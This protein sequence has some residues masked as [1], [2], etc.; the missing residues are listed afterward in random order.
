MFKHVNIRSSLAI[1]LTSLLLAGCAAYKLDEKQGNIYNSFAT[2]DFSNTVDLLNKGWDEE[3]YKEK[4]KVLYNLEKG[5]AHH[6]NGDYEIS[7]QAY[8]NA[9][10][11]IDNLFTKSVSRGIKSFLVNDNLLAYDGE[12]YEDVYL[13]AFNSLNF[14]HQGDF[15]SALVESRRIAYKLE[16]LDIKYNGLVDALSEADT[17]GKVKWEK[18]ESNIQNSAFGHYLSSALFSKTG[19]E[20]NA[21]IEREKVDIALMEQ[22]RI[23]D[24]SVQMPARELDQLLDPREFN[25]MV[26][27]FH[28]RGPQKVQN[29]N[30]IFLSEEDFYMKISL[31]ELR[32]YQSQVNRVTITV[33]DSL[34]SQALL[35]EEMDRVAEEV[36]NVKKPIIYARTYVRSFLKAIGTRAAQ[37]K[38]EKKNENLGKLMGVM[39]VVTQE[40]TEKADLRG[41]QTMPGKVRVKLLKLPAGEHHIK[42]DYLGI[43]GSLYSETDTLSVSSDPYELKLVETLYWN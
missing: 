12:D 13:N 31:P 17:T 14:V 2:H 27:S 19:K 40:A 11:E 36:Y 34:T 33:D 5:T 16:R 22:S 8:S 1:L 20:D 15:E 3:I 39:S 25:V 38:I 35:I 30:R 18:G 7:F 10:R 21:R 29:D 9:E 37:K 32:M 26:V 24:G 4:D 6:F 23:T 28:G 41:W 42:V 43:G